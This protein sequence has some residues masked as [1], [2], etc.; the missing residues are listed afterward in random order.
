MFVRVLAF[1]RTFFCC[2][3]WNATDR[4]LRIADCA[5]VEPS[6]GNHSVREENSAG[7]KPALPGKLNSESGQ[8]E[9][10]L[11]RRSQS[12]ATGGS[13]SSGQTESNP[14]KA[15]QSENTGLTVEPESADGVL[16]S[17]T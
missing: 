14:V 13:G 10:E 11:V 7:G 5:Q 16:E 3:I 15:S 6:V 4:G 12:A 17:A 1:A 8:D 2:G 9:R